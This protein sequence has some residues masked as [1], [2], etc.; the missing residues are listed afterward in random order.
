[1]TV[2]TCCPRDKSCVRG[3]VGEMG[4][5]GVLDELVEVA[6]EVVEMVF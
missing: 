2:W 4:S 3:W 6:G 1:M 5:G